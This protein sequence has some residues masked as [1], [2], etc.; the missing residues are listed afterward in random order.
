MLSLVCHQAVSERYPSVY[1]TTLVLGTRTS[2]FI[3][4]YITSR[5]RN[6]KQSVYKLLNKDIIFTTG[7]GYIVW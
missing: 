1:R 6:D 2:L 4:F 7:V 5:G 3:I